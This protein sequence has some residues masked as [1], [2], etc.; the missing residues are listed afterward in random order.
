MAALP[1]KMGDSRTKRFIAAYGPDQKGFEIDALP[2]S[3]LRQMIRETAAS[4]MDLGEL[5]EATLLERYVENR[6]REALDDVLSGMRDHLLTPAED[7]TAAPFDEETRRR[8][9]LDPAAEAERVAEWRAIAGVSDE[10]NAEDD[11]AED[12]GEDE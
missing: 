9:L 4:Y 1:L 8:Y 10:D 7:P 3:Q 6:A 12:E 5:K 11:D 2:A